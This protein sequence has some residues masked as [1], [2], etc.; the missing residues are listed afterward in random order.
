MCREKT[1]GDRQLMGSIHAIIRGPWDR[2][3][4][5]ITGGGLRNVQSIN[6]HLGDVS[7]LQ[8]HNLT[9]LVVLDMFLCT[10]VFRRMGKIDM[11]C[12]RRMTF[13]KN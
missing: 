11:F 12:R 9:L 3:G 8:G 4:G 10:P 13:C 6:C 7:A 2:I 1:P 5:R